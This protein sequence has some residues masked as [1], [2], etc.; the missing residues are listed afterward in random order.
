MYN[1]YI[2]DTAMIDVNTYVGLKLKNHTY[3]RTDE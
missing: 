1:N 2:E 3:A